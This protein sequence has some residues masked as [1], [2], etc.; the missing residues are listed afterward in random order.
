M[1]T[2][3]TV[4]NGSQPF[5]RLL[6]AVANAQHLLPLP[7]FIQR[8]S[9]SFAHPLWNVRDFIEMHEFERLMHQ[10]ALVIMHAGAGSI[11]NAA[12]AGK[13]PVVMPRRARYGEIVDDHQVEF[14][15][16]LAGEN[17]VM[18]ANDPADL[19]PAIT[20]ACAVSAR[21]LAS[22]DPPLVAHVAR[23]IASIDK[24]ND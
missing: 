12:R 6:R 7:V 3:V 23:L 14:A 19:E 16:A 10:S 8:G 17:L 24:T 9:T 4:G 13:C 15:E 1:T 18:L 5:D 22:D 20:R 11:I 21:R 2:F